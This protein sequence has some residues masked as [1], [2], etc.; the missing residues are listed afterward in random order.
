[1]AEPGSLQLS[2]ETC[3]QQLAQGFRLHFKQIEH[4]GTGKFV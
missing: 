3:F 2:F 4:C 1:M